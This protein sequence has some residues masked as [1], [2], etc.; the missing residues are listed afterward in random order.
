MKKILKEILIVEDDELKRDSWV[1]RLEKRF[2]VHTASH[3][4]GA[5]AWLK[6]KQISLVILDCWITEI[7]CSDDLEQ[8]FLELIS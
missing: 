3:A 6:D 8:P 1:A 4:K 2:V 7:Q 5:M